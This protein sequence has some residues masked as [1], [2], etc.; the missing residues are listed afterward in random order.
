[1]TFANQRCGHDRVLE[2]TDGRHPG[3]ARFM[4]I[5]SSFRL[6]LS[7]IPHLWRTSAICLLGATLLVGCGE[8]TDRTKAQIRLVNASG[9]NGGYPALDLRL[10]DSVRQGNVVYGETAGYVAVEPRDGDNTAIT[11]AGSGTALLTLRPTL[12]E[13]KHSTLLAFGAVGALRQ[14]QLDDEVGQPAS[15]RSLIRIVNAAPDAGALDLY[16]TAAGDPLASAVATRGNLAYGAASEAVEVSASGN[17]RLRITAAGSKSDLRLDLGDV[18]LGDR[19]VTTLVLAPGRGG[20]MVDALLLVQRGAIARRDGAQARVRVVA[21]AA[22]GGSVSASVGG[23]ALMAGV[24]SPAI[25]LYTLVPAG[26]QD[27][28]A[29]I[30]GNTLATSRFTLAAGADHTLLVWGTA[31]APQ[32]NWLADDNRAP[33]AAGQAK[34]RLVNGLSGLATP[35][36]M[37]MDFVQAADGVAAGAASLPRELAANSLARINVTTPGV[38]DPLFAAV[39]QRI[40][41][42]GVYSV[43]VVGAAASPTGI[44]R[45]DR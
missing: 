3:A 32:A 45:R 38:A 1:V 30:D 29:G 19:A 4:S 15:G 11:A 10:A 20:L 37:T 7:G 6:R 39:E 22:L 31:A 21:G 33:A 41:A 13:N 34:L 44:V 16:L 8:G 2:P 35:L 17:W 25:G 36:A 12:A 42:G 27:V 43:F 14:I 23:L 26:A 40:E 28:L 24:G 5:A 18:S 9:A